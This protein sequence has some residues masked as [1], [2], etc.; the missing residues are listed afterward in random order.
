MLSWSTIITYTVLSLTLSE[1]ER[2]A[3][4]S[5]PELSFAQIPFKH[6]LV[7][8]YS[9][10]TTGTPKCMVHSVGVKSTVLTVPHIVIS[11]LT[12]AVFQGTLIQHLKEHILHGN[13][14]RKD[15][16]LYYSTV[17][18]LPTHHTPHNLYNFGSKHG[19]FDFM[20]VLDQF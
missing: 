18:C 5:P 19:G 3:G 15:R 10:G 13:L 9:S 1:F 14:E 6:P 8:M 2:L 7:I 17:S 16:M 20:A 11:Q 12:I 4:P